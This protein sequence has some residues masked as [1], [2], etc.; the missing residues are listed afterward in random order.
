MYKFTLLLD[1]LILKHE[2]MVE[3]ISPPEKNY[4]Q[5]VQL[6]SNKLAKQISVKFSLHTSLHIHFDLRM[7]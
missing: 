7:H 3:L 2:W 1:S 4:F 5:K 6:Y